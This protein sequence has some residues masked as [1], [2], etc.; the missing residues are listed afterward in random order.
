MVLPAVKIDAVEANPI[1][2]QVWCS[3]Q[4][5]SPLEEEVLSDEPKPPALRG[6]EVF[7]L[8]IGVVLPFSTHVFKRK[9][10]EIDAFPPCFINQLLGLM[11]PCAHKFSPT[12]PDYLELWRRSWRAILPS[13]NR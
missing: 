1:C 11:L 12:V 3:E 6:V 13:C 2:F 9:R 5:H 4:A 8:V 7:P 10:Q